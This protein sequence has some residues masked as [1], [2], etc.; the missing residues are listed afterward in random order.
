MNWGLNPPN[1]RQ[2]NNWAYTLSAGV[3]TWLWVWGTN[4]F[5]NDL[6]RPKFLFIHKKFQEFFHDKYKFWYKKVGCGS[7]QT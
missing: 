1:T 7:E 6:F 4:K 3:E 2:F 5:P